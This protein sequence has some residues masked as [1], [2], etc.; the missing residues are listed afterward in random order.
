MTWSP[1]AD[2]GEARTGASGTL[3]PSGKVLVAGGYDPNIGV[4]ASAEVYDPVAD[5]L[6]PCGEHACHL[7][8]PYEATLGDQRCKVVVL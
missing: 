7:R 6:E 3:L 4:V 1:A 2:M 8:V 5:A